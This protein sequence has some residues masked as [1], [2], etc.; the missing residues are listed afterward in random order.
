VHHVQE[1]YAQAYPAYHYAIEHPGHPEAEWG[2]WAQLYIADM[3]TEQGRTQEAVNA[4]QKALNWDTPFDYSQSLE[5]R[6]RLALE[7][8]EGT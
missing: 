6:A 3:Y 8:L 4:Y 7:Q 1:K 5:Q 2:P